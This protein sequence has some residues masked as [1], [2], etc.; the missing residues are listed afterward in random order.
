MHKDA[1]VLTTKDFT[2]L[3]VMLDRCADAGNAIGS[4]LRRKIE[5]A[6]VVFREDVPAAVA[7]L[8]S[9]VTYRINDGE[10]DSRILSHDRM[11]AST[12][13]FL[14]ITSPIGLALLGMAEG[15]RFEIGQDGR[16]KHITLDAILYQPEA[17]H[18]EREA[19]ARMAT[20][21]MRRA[22][23]RLIPGSGGEG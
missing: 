1:C 22:A 16:T 4:L 21:T 19:I 7:T 12:G 20:P 11:N 15:Q 8:N 3:E 14:P 10:P 2:I 6:T 9:R 5:A 17:A 13:L 18:R 23:L